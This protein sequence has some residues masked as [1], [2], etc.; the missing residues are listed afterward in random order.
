VVGHA[1]DGV[2]GVVVGDGIFHGF[3][4]G[5]AQAPRGLGVF[6]PD[7]P[8]GVRPLAGAGQDLRAPGLHHHAA[9]GFLFIGHA[10]HVDG[11]LQSEELAGHGERAAPLPRAGLGSQAPR[12]GLLVVEGLR[13]GGVRLVAAGGT[14]AL[15]LVVDVR[16]GPQGALQPV[17]PVQRCGPPEPVDVPDGLGDLDLPLGG[18]LLLDDLQREEWCQVVRADGLL[19][20][21]VN[22]RRQ[23]QRQIRQNVVPGLRQIPLLQDELGLRHTRPPWLNMAD[24]ARFWMERNVRFPQTESSVR[25]L[26]SPALGVAR[27]REVLGFRLP[28]GQGAQAVDRGGDFVAAGQGV[29]PGVSLVGGQHF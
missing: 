20:G 2:L 15:V 6:R 19:G 28:D 9:V 4:D 26:G 14:G 11:A 8:A 24:S 29:I 22:D 18:D 3:A 12:P 27:R 10:D 23:R 13:Q 5:D 25:R 16:G 17:G 1:A 21:G 7:P